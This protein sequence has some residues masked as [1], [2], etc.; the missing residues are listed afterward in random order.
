MLPKKSR[1]NKL[2]T[3]IGFAFC[4][5]EIYGIHEKMSD[6]KKSKA[7][8][9]SKGNRGW[10]LKR[11]KLLDFGGQNYSRSY[12]TEKKSRNTHDDPLNLPLNTDLYIF[13]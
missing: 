13:R 12:C 2:N 9:L 11:L 8:L 7:T 3:T 1:T 10:V 5:Q 6:P 4:L